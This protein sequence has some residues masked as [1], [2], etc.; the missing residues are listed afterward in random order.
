MSSTALQLF[1]LSQ[2]K[3]KM[4]LEKV[5]V[6]RHSIKIFLKNPLKFTGKHLSC[7]L[8]LKEGLWQVFF[9]ED[10]TWHDI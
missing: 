1:T 3:S 6:Q 2:N 5:V 8:F 7:S 9:S 4:K 10:F